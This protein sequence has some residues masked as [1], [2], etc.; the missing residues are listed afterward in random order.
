RALLRIDA[1]IVTG[2]DIVGV[3]ETGIREC[4]LRVG[5]DSLLEQGNTFDETIARAPEPELPSFQ[6]EPVRFGIRS[7]GA[8]RLML[9]VSSRSNVQP[10]GNIPR[11]VALH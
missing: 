5:G 8:V 10:A 11:N 1:D 6:V 2:S 7:S 9:L 4:V 3:G